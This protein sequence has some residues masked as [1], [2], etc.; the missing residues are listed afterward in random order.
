MYGYN[1]K[2]LPMGI[3]FDHNLSN[4]FTSPQSLRK[5]HGFLAQRP[6][7]GTENASEQTI[8][9]I[10]I[11]SYPDGDILKQDSLKGY[12][13]PEAGHTASICNSNH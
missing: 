13:R 7:K 8:D 12:I 1:F 3:I 9:Q 6:L 10:A 2:L 5:W 4:E 11:H